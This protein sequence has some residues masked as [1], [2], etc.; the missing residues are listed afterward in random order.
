MPFRN[1]IFVSFP[2]S[3]LALGL[4]IRGMPENPA[5]PEDTHGLPPV[6]IYFVIL[7]V[8]GFLAFVLAAIGRLLEVRIS[9][10]G[11][12]ALPLRMV[13]FVPV[14]LAACMLA[15][16]SAGYALNSTGGVIALALALVSVAGAFF[17]FSRQAE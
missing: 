7:I 13:C 11:R 3:L 5:L 14:M 1:I 2:L 4:S 15:V 10:A 16:V 9:R 6:A 17:L 8:M 12:L